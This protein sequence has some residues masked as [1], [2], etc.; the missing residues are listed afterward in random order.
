[1]V[2]MHKTANIKEIETY[3][4]DYHTPQEESLHQ[5]I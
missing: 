4:K 1:M 2:P 3:S 5:N